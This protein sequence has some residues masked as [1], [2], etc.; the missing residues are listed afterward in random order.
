VY[1]RVSL[2]EAHLVLPH[3]DGPTNAANWPFSIVKLRPEKIGMSRVGY[4]KNTS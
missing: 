1:P 3:P 4:L 2:V